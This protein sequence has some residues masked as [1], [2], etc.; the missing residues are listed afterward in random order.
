MCLR[1]ELNKINKLKWYLAGLQTRRIEPLPVASPRAAFIFS[2][3]DNLTVFKCSL[4]GDS[5]S[6]DSFRIKTDLSLS[7][8]QTIKSHKTRLA[9]LPDVVVESNQFGFGLL[10]KNRSYYRNY[11]KPTAVEAVIIGQAGGS[12]RARWTDL[13]ISPDAQK[14]TQHNPF[15]GANNLFY[16][17]KEHQHPH[18]L[19][20][21]DVLKAKT[22]HVAGY[23][24]KIFSQCLSADLT[25]VKTGRDMLHLTNL[26]SLKTTC[27]F[28]MKHIKRD[29]FFSE[30]YEYL[31]Q[32]KK[33]RLYVCLL[34]VG[35]CRFDI[36][37]GVILYLCTKAFADPEP[38]F[39]EFTVKVFSQ[40]FVQIRRNA[41]IE[42]RFQEESPQTTEQVGAECPRSESPL[43]LEFELLDDSL[44]ASLGSVFFDR[45]AD[46]L[47]MLL[48]LCDIKD[49]FT[50]TE[51]DL[52][53]ANGKAEL[54]SAISVESIEAVCVRE[55][56]PEKRCL[57][58]VYLL[59]SVDEGLESV[60]HCVFG[61][62]LKLEI[63]TV[64]DGLVHFRL[65]QD[66]GSDYEHDFDQKVDFRHFD[67][68]GESHQVSRY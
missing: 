65:G 34:T 62:P 59:V 8:Q 45:H 21:I 24:E 20:K 49:R 35:I 27:R 28:R 10:A 26:N 18:Y 47:Y 51:F 63:L 22:I 57:K 61:S 44:E 60:R 50:T 9:C 39:S 68:Y 53:I 25:A 14:F 52:D 36:T 31:L 7:H 30:V 6:V 33:S 48:F 64:L 42:T 12:A 41:P 38:L 40:R 4:E 37:N 1:T 5:V 67:Y 58:F 66:D 56:G 13:S 11:S 19:I 54:N 29:M 15:L 55:P 43:G 2:K 46:R 16:V 3:T 23:I 17:Y 32:I